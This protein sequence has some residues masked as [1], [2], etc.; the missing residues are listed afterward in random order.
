MNEPR[1]AARTYCSEQALQQQAPLYGSAV[2]VEL[3]LLVE[4]PRPWKPKALQDNEFSAAINSH[5]QQLP[6]EVA[7]LCGLRLRVQFVKNAGSADMRRPRVMLA[8]GNGTLTGTSLDNYD[9]LL[10]LRAE[11]L[12]RQT[13]PGADQLAQG[14]YL[15]CTNGQRDLCCARFGLPLY[16]RL[17][18]DLGERVWQ[19]THIGGHRYAPN[20]VCLPSGL[21]YGFVQPEQAP[22]LVSELDAGRLDLQHLRG[23]AALP[24]AA[25]AA[26]YFLRRARQDRQLSSLTLAAVEG[27]DAELLSIRLKLAGCDYRVRL[28]RGVSEPVM[29]SC[30][31]EPK[32]VEQFSLV[33]INQQ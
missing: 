23:R 30:T 27:T 29:A 24:P 21:V 18:M 10:D 33:D 13:L 19:T 20:L 22:A 1:A 14:I 17:R 12:A 9:A 8:G 15:V 3:W 5:L 31:G 6:D 2:Q 11:D 4:Y 16:E 7:Q 28:R 25:Q 26:E 32:P